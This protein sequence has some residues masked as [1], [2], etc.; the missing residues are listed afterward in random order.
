MAQRTARRSGVCRRVAGSSVSWAECAAAAWGCTRCADKNMLQ[1]PPDTHSA[2]AARTA[3]SWQLVA[4][5]RRSFAGWRCAATRPPWVA[6]AAPPPS[7]AFTP[8][9]SNAS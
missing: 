9:S 1:Q 7:Y 5:A 6:A 3:A 2:R 8:V 4:A